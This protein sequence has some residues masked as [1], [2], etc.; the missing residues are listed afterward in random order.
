MLFGATLVGGVQARS[1]PRGFC[2]PAEGLACHPTSLGEVGPRAH[3]VIRSSRTLQTNAEL[4]LRPVIAYA[5]CTALLAN[6]D[7]YGERRTLR[8]GR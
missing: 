8:S 2:P 3:G 5:A 6:N 4:T 7:H 1:L